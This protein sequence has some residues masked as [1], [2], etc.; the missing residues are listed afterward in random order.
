MLP[1]VMLCGGLA[2]RMRPLT[3]DLPKSLI[4]INGEPFIFH[5][6]RLLKRQGIRD[7]ILCVGFLGE[8]VEAAVGDGQQFGLNVTYV[9]EGE[10]LLGT[11]GAIINLG[12]QLPEQFFMMYGDSYLTCDFKAVAARFKSSGKSALMTVYHNQDRFDSS[13]V[14]YAGGTIETYDKVNKIPQMQHID[15]G[16][17]CFDKSVFE[18]YTPGHVIDLA[19]IYIELIKQNQ[20]AGFE[21]SERFY[22]IGSFAGKKEFETL[23]L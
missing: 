8:Q 1:I 13:N 20:L 16:L 18:N 11:G 14:V 3:D 5:Q 19:D 2:K 21:V 17:S 6:L 7:V 4:P 9:Y 12:K 23:T 15:Y 22:E 10:K